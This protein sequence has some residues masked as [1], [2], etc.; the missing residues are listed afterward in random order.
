MSTSEDQESFGRLKP[1]EGREEIAT[2]DCIRR[3]PK[4]DLHCHLDGSLRL[5]TIWDLA[6]SRAVALPAK[7]LDELRNLFS[8]PGKTQRSLVEYLKR[9]D[10]TLAVLQDA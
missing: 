10:Y 1:S 7:S 4:V 9:F 3:L 2:E 8:L 5:E 6:R